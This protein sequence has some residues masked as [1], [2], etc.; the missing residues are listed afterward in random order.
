MRKEYVDYLKDLPIN[1]FFTSI[2]E[3]PLH[4]Q[5]AIEVLFVLKGSVTLG[6][7][8]ETY[9]LNERELEIINPNEVYR[10]ES[11]DEDN[12]VLLIQIDPGF[13][14]RYYDDARDTF[15]YT[16]SSVDN[17]QEDEKYDKLRS[18]ISILLYEAVSKLDDYEDQIEDT[19]LEM[20]YHLLNQFHY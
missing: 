18:F 3:Y 1:I 13:F 16:N 8:S 12:L 10:M 15:F 7:E 6:V 20:M 11:E 5:D 4:W 2:K 19:L 9:N 17:I 14:E